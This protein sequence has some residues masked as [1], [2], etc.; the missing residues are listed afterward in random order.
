MTINHILISPYYEGA[1]KTM[2]AS[3]ILLG[4][5]V[6]IIVIILLIVVI[7][8]N[9]IN[10]LVKT[11]IEEVGTDTLNTAVTVDQVDIKLLGGQLLLEGLS[12]A[13]PEGFTAATI[14]Q[15]DRI[16][17]AVDLLSLL[18]NHVS[19]EQIII[20]GAKIN[21]EQKGSSSNVTTL[22]DSIEQSEDSGAEDSS[23]QSSDAE[24]KPASEGDPVLISVNQFRLANST[25][26]LLT[27][28]WG[29]QALTLEAVELNNI[30]G[31]EGVPPSQLAEEVLRPVVKNLQKSVERRLRDLM[32]EKAKQRLLEKSGEITD[33]LK[34]SLGT[35][36]VDKLKSLFSN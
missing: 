14:F 36:T 19:V 2:K 32:I 15:M 20:D 35:D 27:E 9:N 33:K 25:A 17:V 1:G 30:G 22:L 8:V 3:K 26:T 6:V 13:N 21:A 7:A 24:D 28:Q 23:I 10:T 12:V 29:S 31:A 16:V 5:P 18:D 4:L 11:A 34:E